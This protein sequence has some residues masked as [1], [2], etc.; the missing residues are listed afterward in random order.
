MKNLSLCLSGSLSRK[1]D[2]SP[3]RRIRMTSVRGGGEKTTMKI[4][5]KQT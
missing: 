4:T 2:S 3:P 5:P 1:T